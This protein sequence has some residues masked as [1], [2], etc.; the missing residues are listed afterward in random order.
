MAGKVCIGRDLPSGEID[1][2]QPGLDHLN[3]LVAGEGSECGDIVLGL[4][5][6]PEPFRAA[7]RQ[8]VLLLDR[9]EQANHVF[10]GVRPRYV[11]PAW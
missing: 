8:R 2:V 3:G 7:P 1:R 11:P 4:E 10:L 6:V 9:A 5:Q